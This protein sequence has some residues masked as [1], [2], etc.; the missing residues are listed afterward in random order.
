MWSKSEDEARGINRRGPP[1]LG[2]LYY[3]VITPPRHVSSSLAIQRSQPPQ[4]S[5]SMRMFSSR[6]RRTYH[7][8]QCRLLPLLPSFL[9][10]QGQQR[11]QHHRQQGRQQQH[12]QPRG[13]PRPFRPS[14]R[15]QQRWRTKLARRTKL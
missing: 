13:Q 14:S 12:R 8:H 3:K 11:Q 5:K 2:L 7:R 6:N 1:H 10:W 9:P 15:V 4:G